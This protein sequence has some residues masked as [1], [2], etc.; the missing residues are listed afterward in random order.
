MLAACAAERPPAD[1]NAAVRAAAKWS[2][3]QF[4]LEFVRLRGGGT[5]DTALRAALTELL[6]AGQV[7][8]QAGKLRTG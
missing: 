3:D 2:Q 4:G 1:A 5:I 8:E 6:T 7:R